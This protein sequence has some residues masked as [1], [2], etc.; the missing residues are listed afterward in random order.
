MR[1][2]NA[3]WRATVTPQHRWVD[4]PRISKPK[5]LITA[6]SCHLCDWPAPLRCASRWSPAR[7]A[8]GRRPQ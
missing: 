6:E 5:Q 7:N 1:I 4:L 2:G 8:D 3:R